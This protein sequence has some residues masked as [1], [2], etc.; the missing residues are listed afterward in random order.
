MPDFLPRAKYPEEWRYQFINNINYYA[1]AHS[2]KA[3]IDINYVRE[4]IINLFQGGGVYAYPAALNAIAQDCPIG[5]TGCTPTLTGAN[6]DLR[7]YTTYTQAFD[8]RGAGF[9][10]DVFFTTTDYNFFVQ[11]TWQLSTQLTANFGLSLRVSAAAAA[12]PGL[13]QGRGVHRQPAVS[14]DDELQQGQ[15]QLGPARRHHLRHQRP[16]QDGRA[17]RVGHL[18]RPHQQQ[19]HLELAH[20]QRGDVRDL[21]VHADVG[22]RAAVPQHVFSAPPTGTGSVPQIQYLVARSRAAADRHG[23][24]HPRAPARLGHHGV[25]LL[26]LQQ[27]QPSAD[28]RRQEP[29]AADC[30]GRPHRR[31]RRAAARSRSSAER[32]R[33][34]A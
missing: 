32:V 27:G 15:E 14:A 24:G 3:G 33:T 19:R 4:N 17:R 11:D 21:L 13:G 20:Q 9:N 8:L 6:A 2:I 16:A 22:G 31:R 12:G 23:R 10:G 25:G 34:A 5:A 7:H 18:L 1:G 28:V 26:P 29:A 30:D